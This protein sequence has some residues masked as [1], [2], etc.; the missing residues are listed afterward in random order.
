M[1]STPTHTIISLSRLREKLPMK[2]HSA[3]RLM[4]QSLLRDLAVL[5]AF[6]YWNFRA[7]LKLCSG[8]QRRRIILNRM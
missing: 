3:P 6:I 8:K 2:L 5:R 7:S 4:A 1:H